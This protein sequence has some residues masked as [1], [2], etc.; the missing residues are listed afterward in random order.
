[1]RSPFAKAKKGELITVAHESKRTITASHDDE[2]KLLDKCNTEKRKHLKALIIAAVDTGCR[3]GELLRL[4]WKNVDFQ[5]NTLEVTSYKGKT[6]CKRVV[7]ISDRLRAALL[8][9]R[10][11]PSAASENYAPAKLLIRPLC[12]DSSTTSR[13]P[14]KRHAKKLATAH[15]FSR[16]PPHGRLP[17][18]RSR[19]E[20]CTC[21][22]APGPLRSEDHAQIHKPHRTHD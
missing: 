15:T 5:A 14:L 22:R 17:P 6:V 13:D 9:L 20:H 12:S 7:P 10:T 8:D 18:G 11:K 2:Q 1:M 4:A 3:Q 21:R 16:P 19:N